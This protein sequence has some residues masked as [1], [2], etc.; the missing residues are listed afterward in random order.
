MGNTLDQNLSGESI[1]NNIVNKT[2][3]R[4]KFLYR[5]GS[6]LDTNTRKLHCA[7][8]IQ[9][10]FDYCV[11]SWFPSI[12]N[13]LKSKLQ[14]C[15]NKMARFI[16]RSHPRSHIGD[17]ELRSFGY[18]NTE[19]RASQMMLNHTSIYTITVALPISGLTLVLPVTYTIIMLAAAILFSLFH[20]AEQ[21]FACIL[22]LNTN[23]MGILGTTFF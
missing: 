5:Q 3:S 9:P 8:L 21:C 10:H 19:L 18:L 1:V 15:Q 16:L 20:T 11:S 22:A 12:S 13:Q 2:N 14:I 4:L 23:S 7:A 6:F 17:S